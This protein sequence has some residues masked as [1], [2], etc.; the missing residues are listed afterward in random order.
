MRNRPK[1][2]QGS[3]QHTDQLRRQED[4]NVASEVEPTTDHLAPL[5]QAMKSLIVEAGLLSLRTMLAFEM[6]DVAR[7]Q[8]PESQGPIALA[9]AVLNG[10]LLGLRGETDVTPS[11]T[12][13]PEQTRGAR[14]GSNGR[15]KMATEEE[16]SAVTQRPVSNEDVAVMILGGTPYR[17]CSLITG[18]YI[19]V[20]GEKHLLGLWPGSISEERVCVELL[21]DLERRG[22][23]KATK[24]LYVLEGSKALLRVFRGRF[25]EEVT[26]QNCQSQKES[27]VMAHL[28]EKYQA[29]IRHRLRSAWNEP[30]HDQ[31]KMALD[32]VACDLEDLNP[33]AAQS[34][35]DNLDETLTV[36]KLCLPTILRRNFK[37][38]R[39]VH[40]PFRFAVVDPGKDS[41]RPS[42]E[43]AWRLAGTVLLEAE[44]RFRRIDGC[45]KMSDLLAVLGRGE[46]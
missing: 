4:S 6:R 22:I 44:K 8:S 32:E 18:M 29:P 19:G 12:K 35:K 17:G 41:S 45:E 30:G 28:P 25:G 7:L 33:S 34:L 11:E 24:R 16:V 27:S 13:K 40:N 2:Q 38:T 21:D 39:M 10:P 5:R 42:L 1:T 15:V 3:R 9:Q 14:R 23:D 26:I 31:A 36:H 43:R 46:A 37:S 20:E